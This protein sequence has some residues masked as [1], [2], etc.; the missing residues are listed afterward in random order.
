MSVGSVKVPISRFSSTVIWGKI[1]RPSGTWASFKVMILLGSVLRRSCPSKVME[2]LAAF[3]SP[4]MVRSV[5]VLPAPFAP[6]SETISPSFTVIETP[7]SAWT[8]P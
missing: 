2:P 4:V 6:I 7:F 1:C 5:V 3:S 8:A